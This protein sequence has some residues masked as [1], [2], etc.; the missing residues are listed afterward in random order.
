MLPH[1]LQSLVDYFRTHNP[2]TD[3]NIQ[4]LPPELILPVSLPSRHNSNSIFIRECHEHIVDIA[5][6]AVAASVPAVLFTGPQG[7]GKV[8]IAGRTDI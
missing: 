3:I 8:R 1:I 2:P 5:K 6:K 4:I 7:N